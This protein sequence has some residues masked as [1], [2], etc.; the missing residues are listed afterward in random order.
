MLRNLE[1]VKQVG[2][3]IG[4]H[5]IK[6][7]DLKS[8]RMFEKTKLGQGSKAGAFFFA[9]DSGDGQAT[10][11]VT[12]DPKKEPDEDYV[13]WA[14]PKDKAL[15]KLVIDGTF[16][17]DSG[18]YT[19]EFLTSNAS[20]AACAT[21]LANRLDNVSVGFWRALGLA[22]PFAI[23]LNGKPLTQRK[24]EDIKW[25]AASY[26]LTRKLAD[27]KFQPVVLHLPDEFPI[28]IVLSGKIASKAES[29]A[30]T[31]QIFREPIAKV[32]DEQIKVLIKSLKTIDDEAAKLV[33]DKKKAN[34]AKQE[35]ALAEACEQW[36]KAFVAAAEQAVEEAW[37][38]HA[39][40]DYE[41]ADYAIDATVTFIQKTTTLGVSFGVMIGSVAAAGGSFGGAS[42]VAIMSLVGGIIGMTK[43]TVEMGQEC[44]RLLIGLESL[45]KNVDLHLKKL[46]LDLLKDTKFEHNLAKVGKDV[47][48]KLTSIKLTSADTVKKEVADFKVKATGVRQAAE[49]LAKQ[50]DRTLTVQEEVEALIKL[51]YPGWDNTMKPG[52]VQKKLGL[53]SEAANALGKLLRRYEASAQN[54]SKLLNKIPEEFSRY[55]SARELG[56]KF[57]ARLEDVLEATKKKDSALVKLGSAVVLPLLNFATFDYT[58]VASIVMTTVSTTGEIA[59]GLTDFAIDSGALD[60]V[61]DKL[62]HGGTTEEVQAAKD[63]AEQVKFAAESVYGATE[64]TKGFMATG[65]A[66]KVIVQNASAFTDTMKQLGSALAKLKP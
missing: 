57:Q 35:K 41:R 66:S 27:A 65:E 32:M 9:V 1:I 64:A 3:R 33:K 45:G 55:D 5:L 14:T 51:A 13:K 42:P 37:V 25:T 8:L 59:L 11:I 20:K 50:L 28:E 44:K 7:K 61:A 46:E 40:E 48:N 26:D 43:A 17:Y 29:N 54:I 34:L 2:L 6:P 24:L 31:Q 56:D 10:L 62:S 19:Y 53:S 16:K 63:C 15:Q 36:S 49:K 30:L 18:K 12:S 39:M 52:D 4:K 60:W 22:R 38:E 23:S 21:L 47:L 58:N